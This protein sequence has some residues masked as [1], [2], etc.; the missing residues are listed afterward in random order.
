MM[1]IDLIAWPEHLPIDV[2]DTCA[3]LG[4]SDEIWMTSLFHV[5]VDWGVSRDPAEGSL[6]MR[7]SEMLFVTQLNLAMQKRRKRILTQNLEKK[8]VSNVILTAITLL[9][10]SENCPSELGKE[11]QSLSKF[12]PRPDV[13]SAPMPT[14]FR[15]LHLIGIRKQRD[16]PLKSISPLT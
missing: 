6:T 16:S 14:I 12:V 3:S 4:V 13:F 10:N 8:S 15:R 11:C 5:P 1:H 7:S 9:L 2:S